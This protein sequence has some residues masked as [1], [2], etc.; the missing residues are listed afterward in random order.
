MCVAAKEWL[1]RRLCSIHGLR[2]LQ[3]YLL[4]FSGLQTCFSSLLHHTAECCCITGTTCCMFQPLTRKQLANRNRSSINMK[5]FKKFNA[6]RKWKVSVDNRTVS[7]CNTE[8]Y[9]DDRK[10]GK[11]KGG[12]HSELKIHVNMHISPSYMCLQ[13]FVRMLQHVRTFYPL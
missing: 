3:L 9:R 12:R 1:P 10:W 7:T 2:L 6:R 8:Q 11:G 13:Q 5:N 4:P